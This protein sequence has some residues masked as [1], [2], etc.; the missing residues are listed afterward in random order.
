M[1]N[2][3]DL[4]AGTTFLMDGKP[5]RVVKYSH[6]K[7]ARG[8]GTVKLSARNL[9]TGR[10][11]EKSINSKA[12]V[13]EIATVKKPLQYLYSDASSLVF[14]DPKS[15]EQVEISSSIIGGQASFIKE[16]DIVDVLFWSFGGASAKGG[17]AGQ[18][19][20]MEVLSVEIPPKVTL[21]VKETVPGVK[22]DSATNVYKSAKLENGLELKV[23]LFIKKGDKIKVD[24]RTGEYMERVN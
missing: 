19:S 13:D 15:Y 14:M 5:Y 23:P 4:K 11:E 17:Q 7:I 1:I 9:Q 20:A 16:E 24:T 8:G 22:G 2:A 21:R 18:S 12:K 6:Q 3:T 10:L